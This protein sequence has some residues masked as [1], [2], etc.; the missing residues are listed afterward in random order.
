MLNAAAQQHDDWSH[1]EEAG[2]EPELQA[3][4]PRWQRYVIRLCREAWHLETS[5]TQDVLR[6]IEALI[7]ARVLTEPA[8]ALVLERA[9]VSMAEADQIAPSIRV[10]ITA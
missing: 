1:S 9:G 7:I 5:T 2:A 10:A 3:D 6:K 8:V 4:V